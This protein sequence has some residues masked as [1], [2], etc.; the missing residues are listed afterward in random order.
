MCLA[1]CTWSAHGDNY[2][3]GIRCVSPLLGTEQGMEARVG[4]AGDLPRLWDNA[5]ITLQA[6]C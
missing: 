3:H 1:M 6:R 2:V 4:S 5:T